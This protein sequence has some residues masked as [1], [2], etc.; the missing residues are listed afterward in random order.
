M[1]RQSTNQESYAGMPSTRDSTSKQTTFTPYLAE[2]G[3]LNVRK[4]PLVCLWLKVLKVLLPS[5]LLFPL[6]L[7][8][9]SFFMLPQN[10][11]R[12]L[13]IILSRSNLEIRKQQN[14]IDFKEKITFLRRTDQ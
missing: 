12:F 4:T 3:D 13:G 5:V 7:V 14:R 6:W 1:P 11:H 10:P 2:C 9:S 8:L